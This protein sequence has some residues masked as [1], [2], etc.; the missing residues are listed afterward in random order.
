MT[1]SYIYANLNM[2]QLFSSDEDYTQAQDAVGSILY[3]AMLEAGAVPDLG[4]VHPLLSAN[5]D[6]SSDSRARLQEQ[7]KQVKVKIYV[8][9]LSTV[10]PRHSCT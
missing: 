3:D 9:T 1:L 5:Q 2:G 7:L 8:L 4:V 6:G 10:F